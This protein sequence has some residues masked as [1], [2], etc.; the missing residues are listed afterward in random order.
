MCVI[1]ARFKAS[2]DTTNIYIMVEYTASDYI[3]FEKNPRGFTI[4]CKAHNISS[5]A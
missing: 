3:C 4:Y 2:L 5:M 1:H